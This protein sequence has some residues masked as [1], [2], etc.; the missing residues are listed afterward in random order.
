MLKPFAALRLK[1][2]KYNT[3]DIFINNNETKAHELY[4]KNSHFIQEEKECY[5]IC[6]VRN[7]EKS[8]VG[9]IGIVDCNTV[10]NNITIKHE[11]VFKDKINKLANSF[12]RINLQINPA[13][14]VCNDTPITDD[15][16]SS[17]MNVE[18]FLA[19]TEN[20]NIHEFWAINDKTLI[21]Y[22]SRCLNKTLCKLYI[23]DGHHRIE[24]LIES[25][26]EKNQYFLAMLV[27]PDNIELK[28]YHRLITNTTSITKNELF[29]GISKNFNIEISN[30]TLQLTKCKFQL[31]IEG[32]WYSL[33]PIINKAN[34]MDH[35]LDPIII[36]KYFFKDVLGIDNQA[37]SEGCIDFIPGTLEKGLIASKV[38]RNEALAALLIPP[39]SISEFMQ[40]AR[41]NIILPPNSTYFEP[42][43]VNG[44]IAYKFR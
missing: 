19:V 32:Q 7:I 39:L 29:N 25:T 3:D 10:L 23:A 16:Y 36:D 13:L 8:F 21:S 27:T 9:L 5:Y 20:N 26:K 34:E 43:F 41:K 24:A 44:L 17:V 38:D 11:M 14:L 22:L 40:A 6:R 30:K 15:F 1:D 35:H 2:G 42:K 4:L 33:K 28:S 37:H 18:P 12:K 31:Y